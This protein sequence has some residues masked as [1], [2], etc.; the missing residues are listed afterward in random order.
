[1][2]RQ[3]VFAPTVGSTVHIDVSVSILTQT[4]NTTGDVLW[5][6]NDGNTT[7]T[8]SVGNSTQAAAVS[9]TTSPMLATKTGMFVARDSATHIGALTAAASNGNVSATTGYYR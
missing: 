3:P 6:F 7:V 2:P 1:M 9:N 4:L 8:F 5:V